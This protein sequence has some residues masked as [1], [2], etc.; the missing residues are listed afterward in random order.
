M[1]RSKQFPDDGRADES[2]SAG[3]EYTH[4]MDSDE[5]VDEATIR[6]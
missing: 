3:D 6:P 2:G 5:V 4:E 1:T